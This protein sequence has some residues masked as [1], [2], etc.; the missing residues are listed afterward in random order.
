MSRTVNLEN[1][2]STPDAVEYD[3]ITVANWLNQM[4][5][6][7]ISRQALTP[8]VRALVGAEMH[9]TPLFYFLHYAK[10]ASKPYLKEILLI[11]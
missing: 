4:D 1:P 11:T 6:G 2:N 9:E 8:L 7:Q 5:A 3:S 10:T